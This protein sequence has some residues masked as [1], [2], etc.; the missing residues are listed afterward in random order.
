MIDNEDDE[1]SLQADLLDC[2]FGKY[3]KLDYKPWSEAITDEKKGAWLF[4]SSKLRER[5]FKRAGLKYEMPK[6]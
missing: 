3:S 6:Q 2:V 5:I 1:D 4:T